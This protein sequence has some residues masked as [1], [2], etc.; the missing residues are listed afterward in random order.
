VDLWI[1]SVSITT[2]PQR[3]VAFLYRIFRS[4][5]LSLTTYYGLFLVLDSPFS[6]HELAIMASE[7]IGYNVLVTLRAPPDATVQGV[8]ADVIGQR[9][10]LRDGMLQRPL[11]GDS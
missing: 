7:F 3:C 9:L 11:L 5:Q 10:M 6:S 1:T 2:G 4:E 8:V